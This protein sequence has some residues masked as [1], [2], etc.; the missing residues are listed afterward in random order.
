M[1]AKKPPRWIVQRNRFSLFAIT[2]IIP[3]QNLATPR[4]I[5]RY[6][7]SVSPLKTTILALL[8]TLSTS[9]QTSVN[10]EAIRLNTLGVGYMNQQDFQ[11]ALPLFIRAYTLDPKLYA[12]RLNQGIA[13]LN[14]QKYE[15]AEKILREAVEREPGNPRAWYNLG[16]L[17]KSQGE[18]RQALQAFQKVAALDPRD[19]DVQYFLGLVY[20]D[21]KQ[22][23]EAAQTL[24]RAITLDRFQVSAEYALA[25]VYRSMGETAKTREHLA[26]F[27][28]VTNEK[29][30][31][32]LG[33]GY[34]QQGKYS[35]AE[36]VS[37]P[38]APAPPAI[39]VTFTAASQSAGLAQPIASPSTK[40]LTALTDL[41]FGACFFDYDGDG[42]PDLFVVRGT[43][44][45]PVLY[46]NLGNAGFRDVTRSSGISL[47][48]P[49]IACTAG[50]YD[51]D[52]R[53]DLAVSYRGGV[54]LFHNEGNGKFSNTTAASGIV[55]PGD[56]LGLTFVDCDHDGYLDLYVVRA[57]SVMAQASRN[58]VPD[59]NNAPDANNS[60]M[61]WKN[62]A[63]GTF[64]NWTEQGTLGGDASSLGVLAT[65]YN[66]DHAID[67]L[68]T[69]WRK[70]PLLFA[71]LRENKFAAVDLWSAPFPSFTAGVAALDFN[72]D[73]WMDL[74]FTHMGSPGIT[75]WRNA[76]GRQFE[77][78]FL[79]DLQWTQAYGV[80]TLDY[81][82]DGWL[83]IAAVGQSG[84]GPEIRLLRNMGNGKFADATS[85]TG[86]DR[87]K[88]KA[89]RALIAAD[90]DG[91][92]DTDLLITQNNGQVVLLRNDGGNRNNWVRLSLK[93]NN[94]NK[95]AIGAQVQLFAGPTEQK[96]EIP[97]A[98]GYLGQSSTDIIAGLGNIKQAE[99]V[100]MRWPTGVVQDELQLAA[101][102]TQNLDEIDRRSS[103]CPLLVT[104]NG[105]HFEFI[106]DVIGA[107]VIGHWVAP[108]E[109]NLPDP[110]EYIKV[111]GDQLQAEGGML[112]M[113]FIEPMEEVNYL[114]QARL[115]AVDHPV[116]VTI[117]PNE[118]FVSGP[119]FPEFK[120]IASRGAHLPVDARD[121]QGRG[122]LAQLAKVDHGYVQGFKILQYPGF[123]ETHTL[124]LDLGRWDSKKPLRLLMTGYTEY[125]TA[126]SMFVAHQAGIDVIA[127]YVEALVPGDP[128]AKTVDGDQSA[129]GA[130]SGS[131]VWK[132]IID[133]MGFPAGLPRT[134][135]VDLTGH[136]P[137]GARRIRIVTNLQIYWDQILV[138]NSPDG[139]P[140]RSMEVPLKNAQL[141]FRGFP[142]QIELGTPGDLTY[143]YED[144]SLTGPFGRP[145]GN[146]T[147]M[148]DALPLLTKS[149][150]K[151]AIFGPG[152]EVALDFDATK[153]PPVPPGWKRDYLF[154]AD[155][156]VKDMDFFGSK[157]ATVDP[158]PFHKMG[159]YPYP[160]GKH[161]PDSGEF[162]DYQL[163][164]NTRWQSEENPPRQLRFQYP[165][166][167]STTAGH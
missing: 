140:M 150:D 88:L 19:A 48:A 40:E 161:Y 103:S 148:G 89:P 64:S 17:Y 37:A 36:Q 91:D 80:V 167:T 87:L 51:N 122:L 61:L 115:M 125:F 20:F 60:N 155:G 111:T 32:P 73:G 86:L 114:D 63:N 3:A 134:I 52:S 24:Q 38:A 9:A 90:Y 47:P 30:G 76:G 72:K 85:A 145:L 84:N 95:S 98:S 138:D 100:R 139:L 97:A 41:G 58:A 154:Y 55:A 71:S 142:K 25:R 160:E 79:P 119:P 6:T 67:L 163:T 8:F 70:S 166:K 96:W 45:K 130:E 31:A 143:N 18:A 53:T 16:L 83:D 108:G 13:F 157:V 156:F 69:G 15:P 124:E 121:G 133:D 135:T 49:G 81:D 68:V 27:Q 26:R 77:P 62:N 82:N 22:N 153:L 7:K 149:D 54:A 65:D 4:P 10:L 147:R 159:T 162:L 11:H 14:Q 137:P 136:L 21:L 92:G 151:F 116:D 126:S 141:R 59:P 23:A 42:R 107:G 144:I 1:Q 66:N 50:D 2:Q 118:R 34:G 78:V 39:K 127:P 131:G 102:V 56:P 132:K 12:A 75:L 93:G 28:K 109:R 113:K 57:A 146:Y 164:Y 46:H 43:T 105:K 106:S 152:E 129:S 120:I 123:T 99:V 117:H 165:A 112:S 101:G 5:V 110:T 104:W 35:F 128:D 44:A 158:L 29:A 94:D 74:V 33:I